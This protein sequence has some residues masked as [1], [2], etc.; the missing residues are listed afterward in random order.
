MARLT[1][2]LAT[3]IAIAACSLETTGPRVPTDGLPEGLTASLTVE[4]NE[5]AQH[6]RFDV[7]FTVTNTS[8]QTVQVV[9]SG[10]CLVIPGVYRNGERIPFVGSW[11]GCRAVITTHTFEPGETRTHTWEMQAERYAEHPGDVDGDPVAK[12]TYRVTAEFDVIPDGSG[13]R[14]GVKATLRVQ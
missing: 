3:I 6:E 11:W 10:G 13:Q 12:G 14:P 5:V 2:L 4:P 9:T 1:L 7:T 8:S